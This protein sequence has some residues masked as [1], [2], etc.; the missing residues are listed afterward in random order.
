LQSIWSQA[1]HYSQVKLSTDVTSLLFYDPFMI[2]QADFDGLHVTSV[3][4]EVGHFL[5]SNQI[6][7]RL[8]SLIND[9]CCELVMSGGRGHLQ[10]ANRA[11]G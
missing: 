9:Y 6:G 7:K 5:G 8:A 11:Y 2:L 1:K 10:V 4:A 3:H